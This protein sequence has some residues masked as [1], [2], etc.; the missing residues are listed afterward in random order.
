MPNPAPFHPNDEPEE[1]E[2]LTTIRT[3]TELG[4]GTGR[5]WPDSARSTEGVSS[6]PTYSL[7]VAPRN[8]VVAGGKRKQANSTGDVQKVDQGRQPDW[9]GS[10]LLR[11]K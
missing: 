6:L 11:P 5:T 10:P 7:L 8:G 3:K 4:E 2:L 1:Q 9:V